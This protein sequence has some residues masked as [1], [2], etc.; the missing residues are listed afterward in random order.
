MRI[1]ADP[2]RDHAAVR[3]TVLCFGTVEKTEKIRSRFRHCRVFRYGKKIGSEMG[4]TARVGQRQVMFQRERCGLVE[5]RQGVA[6]A[7]GSE[8][9]LRIQ[10][11]FR[12]IILQI[13]FAGA[14]QPGRVG[15]I[16]AEPGPVDLVFPGRNELTERS[17]VHDIVRMV[18]QPGRQPILPFDQQLYQFPEIVRRFPYARFFY[19]VEIDRAEAAAEADRIKMIRKFPLFLAEQGSGAELRRIEQS[20]E[21]GR[22][23]GEQGR[24]IAFPEQRDRHLDRIVFRIREPLIQPVFQIGKFRIIE[25]DPDL[26]SRI[27]TL[28]RSNK[29]MPIVCHSRYIFVGKYLQDPL[30]RFPQRKSH[31]IQFMNIGLVRQGSGGRES[32]FAGL[33]QFAG[34]EKTFQCAGDR[35][36]VDIENA[37]DFPLAGEVGMIRARRNVGG[38]VCFQLLV[39]RHPG[40]AFEFTELRLDDFFLNHKMLQMFQLVYYNPLF[41]DVKKKTGGKSQKIKKPPGANTGRADEIQR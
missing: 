13:V 41:M 25:V 26:R 7:V 31:Q 11:Q 5:F 18:R 19:Q 24:I 39:N 15:V 9:H 38:D 36:P 2:G 21:G 35:F 3:E 20:A 12:Q 30:I 10:K 27:L 28:K 8:D 32:A 17:D 33:E 14:E 23:F 29:P 22:R 16:G 6:G 34:S 4:M 40:P 37:G 1:G